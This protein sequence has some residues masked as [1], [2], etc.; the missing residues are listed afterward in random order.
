MPSHAPLESTDLVKLNEERWRKHIQAQELQGLM[1]H[2]QGAAKTDA[3]ALFR[4]PNPLDVDGM[5]L[6]PFNRT[7]DLHRDPKATNYLTETQNYNEGQDRRGRIIR[8]EEGY[9]VKSLYKGSGIEDKNGP[10]ETWKNTEPG[11]TGTTA[12]STYKYR[13]PNTSV[14]NKK[15]DCKILCCVGY[16]MT[17]AQWIWWLN[18]FCFLAHIT[19]IIVVMHFAYF[20]NIGKEELNGCCADPFSTKGTQHMMVKIYRISAVP[21]MDMINR[22]VTVWSSN[23]WNG[24][25]VPPEFY[26][27]PNH[28][29]VNYASLVISFFAISAVFHFIALILGLFENFWFWYW[30]CASCSNPL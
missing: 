9:W 24:T 25:L 5:P 13:I 12:N 30:R 29:D 4:R 14:V 27:R 18:L 8:G 21:T 20:R 6:V 1:P 15:G 28:L 22:N 17:A 16:R 26:L 7:E 23:R 10:A 3:S 2:G 11:F 19:M